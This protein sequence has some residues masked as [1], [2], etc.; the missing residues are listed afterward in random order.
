MRL[1][2]DLL[3]ALFAFVL[4]RIQQIWEQFSIGRGR[5]SV[6]DNNN[7]TEAARWVEMA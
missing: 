2:N 1:L 3:F 4:V 5:T 6:S 7:E